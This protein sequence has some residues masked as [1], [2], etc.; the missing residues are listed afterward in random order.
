MTTT[1]YSLLQTFVYNEKKISLLIIT[2]NC[3]SKLMYNS[4]RVSE[5]PFE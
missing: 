3:G 1:N 4:K 5:K 2:T